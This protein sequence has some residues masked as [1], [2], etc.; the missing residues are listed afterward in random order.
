MD[1]L[2]P[3]RPKFKNEPASLVLNRGYTVTEAC[4]SLD[5][6]ET[7]LRRWVMEYRTHGNGI[8]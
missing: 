5:V 8:Q 6:D 4:R 2:G 1:N 7:T 3:Y